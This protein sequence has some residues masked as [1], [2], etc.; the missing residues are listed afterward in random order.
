MV[1]YSTYFLTKEPLKNH[2]FVSGYPWSINYSVPFINDSLK[3]V[4]E[5]VTR[6]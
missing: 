4:L 3:T 5:N 1:V 6:L 2:L